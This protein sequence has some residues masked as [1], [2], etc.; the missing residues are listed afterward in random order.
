M[1]YVLR[2][3]GVI[4]DAESIQVNQNYELFSDGVLSL[5]E[6]NRPEIVY[7]DFAN[8][9][10]A[11]GVWTPPLKIAVNIDFCFSYLD[12][13]VYLN[14]ESII[15]ALIANYPP[16]EDLG[17]PTKRLQSI[18]WVTLTEAEQIAALA[19]I[20]STACKYR[21][22]FREAVPLA[23]PVESDIT[24]ISALADLI[25]EKDN[26][27]QNVYGITTG[28][29]KTMLADIRTLDTAIQIDTY[30]CDL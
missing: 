16:L 21:M 15:G 6:I 29:K 24:A 26:S 25:I 27:F 3:N 18:A 5:P 17:F 9:T 28:K 11:D 10:E 30:V 23:D 22:L 1:I 8:M 7:Y 4:V 19:T 20:S 13:I 14:Y 2:E 12:A